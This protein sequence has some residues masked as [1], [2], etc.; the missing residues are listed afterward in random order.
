MSL[1]CPVCGV[2]ADYIEIWNPQTW[3]EGATAQLFP[4][5]V[6][7]LVSVNAPPSQRL[8][9]RPEELLQ[10]PRCGM[11]YL[12]RWWMPG[13]SDDVMHTY[14]HESIRRIGSSLAGGPADEG[15]S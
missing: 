6:M 4:E 8:G 1:D 14:F 12:Y 7:H 9:E 11:S 10:C 2:L 15:Q 5:A 13:G 3:N